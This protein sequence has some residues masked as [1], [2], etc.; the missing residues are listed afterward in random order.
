MGAGT[1]SSSQCAVIVCIWHGAI[2]T[3]ARLNHN[4]LALALTES[5]LQ[6]SLLPLSHDYYLDQ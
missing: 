5:L 3:A 1:L 4:I 2:D 6:Y